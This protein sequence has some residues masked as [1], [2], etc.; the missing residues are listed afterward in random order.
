LKFVAPFGDLKPGDTFH[1]IVPTQTIESWGTLLEVTTG[2]VIAVDQNNN[3]A[4]VIHTLGRGKT[5]LSAYP[6][7][8][9]LANIPAVFD[10]PENTHRI[11]E[12]FRDWT[13][14]K[15]AFAANDPAI[16]I[17]SLAGDHRGY[18][19]VVNHAAEAKNVRITG[20]GVRSASKIEP[21]ST[22]PLQVNDSTWNMQLAP[23]EGAIID[24]K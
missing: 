1:Y 22:T 17:T 9:Y 12:A 23:Y 13:G 20:A 2:K 15:P 6:I 5:L 10:G 3:P 14:V 8:H 19:V 4:L 21:Q 7:E 16:E 18:A 24:W 11:Y